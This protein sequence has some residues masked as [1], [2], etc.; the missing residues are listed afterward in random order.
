MSGHLAG[1]SSRPVNRRTAAAPSS[2]RAFALVSGRFAGGSSRPGSRR[3]AAAPSSRRA[4]ALASGRFACRC[5]CRPSPS[6][7]PLSDCGVIRSSCRFTRSRRVLRMV[8][9]AAGLLRAPHAVLPGGSMNS[10][11]RKCERSPPFFLRRSVVSRLRRIRLRRKSLNPKPVQSLHAASLHNRSSAYLLVRA[12]FGREP[13]TNNK[14]CYAN[15]LAALVVVSRVCPPPPGVF[16]KGR[17]RYAR[18]RLSN[19][20][21]PGSRRTA[22]APSSRRAFALAAGRGAG[23]KCGAC[24]ASMRY[25]LRSLN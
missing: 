24:G 20:L 9:A 10:A 22:A 17:A 18:R 5:G 12:T 16:Y 3:T 6:A 11:S 19:R 7:C 13:R 23:R 2:R 1:G 8:G 21:R 4:F 14:L 25:S 15:L